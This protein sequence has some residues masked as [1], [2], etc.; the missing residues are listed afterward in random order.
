[1][2]NAPSN[3]PMSTTIELHTMTPEE[4]AEVQRLERLRCVLL[5]LAEGGRQRLAGRRDVAAVLD[6]LATR[7]EQD[8]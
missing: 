2:S 1:M 3:T 5:V 4:I 7:M 8:R 6:A